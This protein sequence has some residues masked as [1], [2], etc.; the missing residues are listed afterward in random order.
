METES[1]PKFLTIRG[2]A[3]TGLLP[4]NAL[5]TLAKAGR[6]PCIYVGSRCLVNFTRL[7][8]ALNAP[9]QQPVNATGE[10]HSLN[11]NE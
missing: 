1:L 11:Q 3:A 8:D 6:L 5:R 4:E 9:P 10:L 2:V 7:V